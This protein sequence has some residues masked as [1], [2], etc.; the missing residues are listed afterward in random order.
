[1]AL[2]HTLAQVGLAEIIMVL[3]YLC[4]VGYLGWLGFKRTKTAADYMVAGRETHPFIMALSYGATFISTS[5]IVGFGGVAGMF[6]MS[7]LWLTFLNIFIG[8]FIAFVFLGGPTR[9]LGHR[10][11]AHTFPELLGRR[12]QSKFIQVVSGLIIFLFIPLYAAAV[13]IGGCAFIASQF[14]IS[15]EVALFV[16]SAIIAVYVI[17]GGLKG[18]M[19]TDALQGSIMFIGMIVLLA[20]T[21]MKVGGVVEGHQQLVELGKQPNLFNSI[22][23]KG[24]ASMPEFGWG[25]KKFD[26]WWIVISTITLGV[27]IGVLA[28]PQLA[29]RFMTVKSKRELNR[30][31]LIGGV[32]ILIMTG[33]A[34]TVGSLSNVF[35]INEETVS[36]E[37]VALD[38]GKVIVKRERNCNAAKD[39]ENPDTI[40]LPARVMEIKQADGSITPLIAR[41]YDLV[42][43]KEGDKVLVIDETNR[44]SEEDTAK[45][46]PF[47]KLMPMAEV[48]EGELAVGQQVTVKPHAN[49]YMRAI[50]KRGDNLYE[51]MT[52]RIIPFYIRSAMP[53]WFGMVFLLTLLAAAMSTLSSQFHA[54]GTSI[55]RDV[56]EQLTGRHETSVNI[57]RIGIIIGIIV[58]V[59]ISYLNQG[60]GFIIARATAIFFGLCASAFLPAFLGALFWKRATKAGAI[61]SMLVGALITAFWLLLVKTK[62]AAALGVVFQVTGDVGKPSILHGVGNWHVVDPIVVALP[63][64]IIVL[65]VVSLITK[66]SD[67][68]H[69]NKCFGK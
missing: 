26:L 43:T 65:V 68:A 56:V 54:V 39:P 27:G 47:S 24:W 31:C 36:G 59:V 62:E 38:M 13:L 4:I 5:A 19:Y 14:G 64:S 6:G 25:E 63:I 55:G 41:S 10:L 40:A 45:A 29:V 7:L 66:K 52:S 69:L 44:P 11:G 67:D 21:Y 32:F 2:T 28:Q 58:A 34:F 57:T 20:A 33:V 23:F 18:V 30:A 61:A 60:G 51:C 3:V 12:Y 50:E 17:M 48:L 35:F 16:F 42:I 1:M 15:Y 46:V 37:V 53:S 8:I 49:A 9:K 22:G